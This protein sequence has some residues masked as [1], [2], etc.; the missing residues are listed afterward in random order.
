VL[1][2]ANYAVRLAL[3]YERI[4]RHEKA[5]AV[6]AKMQDKFGESPDLALLRAKLLIRRQREAEAIDVLETALRRAANSERDPLRRQLLSLRAARDAFD[7]AHAEMERMS[8]ESPDDPRPIQLLIEL[9]L[10]AGDF[11]HARAGIDRL[12]A[13]EEHRDDGSWPYYLAQALIAESQQTE[14]PQVRQR[15]V[16][17][18]SRYGQDLE[19]ARPRWAPAYLLK[20]RLS[21]LKA[22]PDEN[23]AIQAYA[24]SLR[25]GERRLAVYQELV[26]LLFKQNRIAEADVYLDQLREMENISP[27]LAA[28][29]VAADVWDG[30]LPRAM[31][32]ARR[33]LANRPQDPLAHLRLGQLLAMPAGGEPAAPE[34]S[35]E[36]ESEL[37]R[38]RELAPNDP[39]GWS[40]LLAFY[41]RTGQEGRARDLLVEVERTESLEEADRPFF[42][43]QGYA[44]LGDPETAGRHYQRA[45]EVAS[46]R[47]V[48]LIQAAR[49][50]WQIAPDRAERYL[51]RAIECQLGQT[52]AKRLLAAFLA[53][54]GRNQEDLDEAW[55]LIEHDAAGPDWDA[56]DRRLQAMLHLQQGGSQS[57]EQAS[58]AMQAIVTD[59]SQATV[60]DHLLLAKLYEAQNQLDKAREQLAVLADREQSDPGCL[61]TYIDYLIRTSRGDRDALEQAGKLLDQLTRLEPETT[62]FR[63]FAL[64]ARWLGLLHRESEAPDLGRQLIGSQ[65]ATMDSAALAELH[66][67]VAGVYASLNL[68]A[69][70]EAAYRRAAEIEPS[71][72]S[73]LAA[74]L[75][76]HERGE[77]AVELCLDRAKDDPSARP[78]IALA[79][80]LAAA[81]SPPENCGRAEQL[82]GQA[83]K[84]FSD[85][86]ELLFTVAALRSMSGDNQQAIELLRRNLKLAPHDAAT[87]NNLAMVLCETSEGAVE[88]LKCIEAAM[89]AVGK[90]PELLDTKGWV[91][92]RQHKHDQAESAFRDALFAAPGNPKYRFHLAI[93][94]QHQGKR[95]PARE[96]FDQAKH[97]GLAAEL[98]S[99]AERAE[100]VR[101]AGALD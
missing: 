11:R 22:K 78:A 98:L 28:L 71:Q 82:I 91:L 53:T 64:R 48:V 4:G 40:A 84:R 47:P 90:Q 93:N 94:L 9:D 42:L 63:S 10:Q 101:L 31:E 45:V 89:G 76:A 66:V 13:L 25:L 7:P 34:R 46:D 80:A 16:E 29:A 3:D 74:W 62:R 86:P 65:T 67:R 32:T 58:H 20:A 75:A 95:V 77:E 35:A 15:L 50:F 49:F 97:D 37:S 56:A 54:R 30:N 59:A 51:R 26:S 2:S 27:A 55:Q 85:D 1:D 6:V 70:A 36:A 33:D 21:L 92:L 23:K 19:A 44:L 39:R 73:Q 43:A 83:L 79:A 17:E 99:P 72:Y 87:L 60:A 88:A 69:E 12:R 5:D 41:R 96:T 8:A 81:Q 14:D 52:T 100:L 61:A 24:Q 18:A 68:V 38:A 57:R